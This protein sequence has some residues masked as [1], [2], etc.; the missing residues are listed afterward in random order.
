MKCD[1]CGSKKDVRYF[2]GL[3]IYK[4]GYTEC[5]RCFDKIANSKFARGVPKNEIEDEWNRGLL[6]RPKGGKNEFE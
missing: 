3:L 4:D 5:R 1:V 6:K 2:K